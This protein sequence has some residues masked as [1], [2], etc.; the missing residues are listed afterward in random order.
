MA[1]DVE[2][3]DDASGREAH[4]WDLDGWDLDGFIRS[5]TAASANTTAAYRRDVRDFA[6]WAGRAGHVDATSV[7]RRTLRRYL[8]YLS[9][10]NY[11]RRSIARKASRPQG[12]SN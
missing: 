2:L 4:S 1:S 10:R 11:A 6:V 5:L 7:D 3:P 12:P 9:T 8:A